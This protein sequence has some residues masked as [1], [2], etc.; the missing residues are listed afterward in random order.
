[1][2]SMRVNQ[3][4]KEYGLSVDPEE[5]AEK[6]EAFALR[7]GGRTP[8]VARQFIEQIKSGVL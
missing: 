4:A 3:L 5:L 2:P 7:A 6:A 8:R 1:M